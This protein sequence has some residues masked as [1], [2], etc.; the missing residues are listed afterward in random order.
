LSRGVDFAITVART[1]TTMKGKLCGRRRLQAAAALVF[2]SAALRARG[3]Y[4]SC[5]TS[6]KG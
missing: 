3:P 4:V 1:I 2:G 6:T 5:R